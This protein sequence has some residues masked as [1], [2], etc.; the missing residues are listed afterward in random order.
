MAQMELGVPIRPEMIFRIGSITKQFTAAAI[1]KLVEQGKLS[2]DDDV[3]KYLPEYPTHGH[4]ITIERLL[5][6]TSGIANY[7]DQPG[8]LATIRTD[9]TPTQL[10]AMF[11]DLP[12]D[13]AP[14]EKWSYTNSGYILLGAI[15]QKVSGQPY[16]DY[17][18]KQLLEPL[19]LQ[20]TGY[21]NTDMIIPG[22]VVGY[23]Y[24]DGSYV[25]NTYLSMSQPYAAGGLMSTVDDLR[26]WTEAFLGGKVVSPALVQRALTPAK[27]ANGT[28]TDY[29]YGWAFGTFEGHR[30]IQHGGGIFGFSAY[31][32][33][34]PDDHFFVAVL[35]NV[36]G[37][38]PGTEYVA[39]SLAALALGRPIP[40]EPPPAKPGAHP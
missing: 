13:F 32:L 37:R 23:G 40:K 19:G 11:K 22:R 16:P 21:D 1:L 35:S 30:I 9:Q 7:T 26:R 2:L 3:T 24:L 6:H 27:L 38:K 29:G 20:Q 5:S 18:E 31:E 36:A 39:R 34:M 8:W 14:G 33:V 15:I 10:I 4:P 25:N 12:P 28:P 17:I